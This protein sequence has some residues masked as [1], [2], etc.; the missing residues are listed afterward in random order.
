MLKEFLFIA[1]LI[2][3]NRPNAEN[4]PAVRSLYKCGVTVEKQQMSQLN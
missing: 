1:S 2:Q 3:R 4:D